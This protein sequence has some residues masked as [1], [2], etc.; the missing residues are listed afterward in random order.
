MHVVRL[1]NRKPRTL[2]T[3]L[4][5]RTALQS[6]QA[7]RSPPFARLLVMVLTR[8]TSRFVPTIAIIAASLTLGGCAAVKDMLRPMVC[9]CS[10]PAPVASQCPPRQ[11]TPVERPA[12]RA[13]SPPPEA[14]AVADG[15]LPDV[16]SDPD[17]AGADEATPQR[18]TIRRAPEEDPLEPVDVRLEGAARDSASSD[19]RERFPIPSDLPEDARILV[20]NFDHRPGDDL[21]VVEAGRRI[22]IFN[23]G[24]RIA[25]LDIAPEGAAEPAPPDLDLDEAVA[26]SLFD[27]QRAQILTH[28]T[29]SREDGSSTVH[30]AL[31]QVITP[32]VGTAFTAELARKDSDSQTW[33]PLGNYEFLRGTQNREIRWIPANQDGQFDVDSATILRWNRWEGVFRVPTPPPTAPVRKPLQ[34][35]LYGY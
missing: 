22:Q 5:S 11:Q 17:N 23:A 25:T 26:V 6:R 12:R 18:R 33:T 7:L 28:W 4:S 10:T 30:V 1:D 34:S 15:Q 29:Q 9:D 13:P 21:A 32:F 3:V 14:L 27:D 19:L 31:F 35:T 20:A 24:G 8:Q 2:S 16:A